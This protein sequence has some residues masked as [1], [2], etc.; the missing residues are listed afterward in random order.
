[1]SDNNRN[2]KEPV[3][4]S[5]NFVIPP[6]KYCP[7]C[8]GENVKLYKQVP[9]CYDCRCTFFVSFSRYLRKARK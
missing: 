9:R 6:I 8:G 3:I 2:I 5:G 7:F 1:M 4:N